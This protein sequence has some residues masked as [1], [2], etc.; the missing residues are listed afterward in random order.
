MHRLI[1]QDVQKMGFFAYDDLEPEEIDL[2]INEQIYAFIEAVVDVT[3]GRKPK[4]GIVEGFQ[5]DQ[6]SLDSLRTIH[7]KDTSMTLADFSDGEKFDLPTNYL[8]H[9][10]TKLG[11]TYTCIEGGK[12][13]TKTLVPKATLRLGESQ[14]IEIMRRSSF[15]KTKKESPLG[16]LV[17]STVY[18]YE[19]S[20][21]E[22]TTAELDYIKRP[23]K[24]TYVKDGGGSYDPIN[25]IQCDLPD[26][27]LYTIVNMTVLKILKV[28]ETKQQKI[29]NL[30]E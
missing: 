25:S 21:F 13:V 18:I 30:Q 29:V 10:K 3:K 20:E 12:S 15:Y 22:I 16:E 7:L 28:I 8:H 11:I 27:V 17:G 1:E 5:E 4:I 23:A 14:N 19:D 24:V 26:T 2:K 6:V 9:V